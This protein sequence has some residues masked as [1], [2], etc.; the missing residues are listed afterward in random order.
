[1]FHRKFHGLAL[2]TLI[3]CGCASSGL[4]GQEGVEVIEK[5]DTID[6]RINGTYFTT[7][8]HKGY[9]RPFL[10]PVI[11]PGGASMTRDWPMKEGEHDEEDHPHHR[12]LWYAHGDI[13]GVDFW[14]ESDRAGRTV[15]EELIR[16][17]SGKTKGV[18]QTRNKLVS[19]DGKT[20][21][22]D[23]R[24][25]TFHNRSPEIVMD[26]EITIQATE[27]D[28]V[29]GDTKE[30]S[31]GIR[32]APTMRLDGD[33]AQGHIVNSE[34]VR[35]HDTWGKR[36]KWVDYYGPVDGNTV[37]VAILDSPNNPRHPTWWHVR[38]YGLFAANPFGLHYFEKKPEGT[39]DF[40]IA[41]GESATWKYRFVFHKGTTAEADIESFFHEFASE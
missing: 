12:S 29:L 11:G 25:M 6:V 26:F 2:C 27:G 35:D 7:H 5:G 8:Q 20:I 39:G 23:I 17:Q 9:S 34:G 1:M 33:V 38:P 13:N 4:Q 19:R 30:G 36:A 18:I 22:T 15:Q 3:V 40:K 37:G 41:K 14:S 21:A 16:A 31:M 24:T 28:L 10:Y 32:V